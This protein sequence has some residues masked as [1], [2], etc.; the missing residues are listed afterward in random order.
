M[1]GKSG[2]LVLP[3]HRKGKRKS[4]GGRT[5]ITEKISEFGKAEGTRE[6]KPGESVPKAV[7]N[8]ELRRKRGRRYKRKKK[9][10]KGGLHG[11]SQPEEECQS[12]R[13]IIGEITP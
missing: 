3:R 6:E 9:C 10:R 2:D 13:A 5:I 4:Q 8:S 7:E 12:P 11:L 1:G